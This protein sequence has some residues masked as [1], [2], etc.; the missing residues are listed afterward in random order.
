MRVA[1]LMLSAFAA[2]LFID[3]RTTWLSVRADGMRRLGAHFLCWMTLRSLLGYGMVDGDSGMVAAGWL[4]GTLLLVV[5]S[6]L[7]W[8]AAQNHRKLEALGIWMGLAA[9]F[10]AATSFLCFYLLL[11][12]HV[13]GERLMNAFVYGGWNPVSSGLTFG[14]AAVWLAAEREKLANPRERRIVTCALV[15]L[16]LAVCFT[17]SRGAMLAVSVGFGALLCTRGLRRM[18]IPSGLALACVVVFACSGPVV[19]RLAL[20]QAG[21]HDAA[22][23]SG[24]ATRPVAEMVSRWDAGRID[25][26]ERALRSVNGPERSLFGIGQ[27]GP[28]E[29]CCRSLSRLQYHLHSAFFATFVHGG[30]VGLVLLLALLAVGLRRAVSLARR[31][32][33]T[34]VALLAYGCMG[35]LFDGQT[36]AS[37]TSIPQVETLL[38][39]FPLVAASAIWWHQRIVVEG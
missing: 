36:F 4:V 11:P 18:W 15:V 31:G 19:E 8:H 17:R 21:S 35:L 20:W 25:L 38:M 37:F 24:V 22:A 26:Y 16:M 28:E 14:F 1:W 5:F 12:G 32:Q 30:V 33:D 34:W 10:A 7:V 27:W 3:W 39:A 6:V 29:A 9:A 2:F 13:F 23:A